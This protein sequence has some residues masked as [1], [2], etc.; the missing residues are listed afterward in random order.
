MKKNADNAIKRIVQKLL[1]SNKAFIVAIILFVVMSMLSPNFLSRAN[2]LNLLKQI[3]TNTIAALGFTFLIGSGHIDLSVGSVVGFLGVIMGM[4]IVRAGMPIW[5]AILVG[6]ICGAAIGSLSAIIIS[7]FSLPPFVVTLAMQS[8]FRG[9]IYIITKLSPITGFPKEFIF[10]GQGNVLGF[11]MPVII[12]IAM[13]IIMYIVSKR[14]MFGRYV[15]AMGGNTEATRASG[16]SITKTRIAIYAVMGVCSAIASVILTARV[17][18]ATIGAGEG[19]ELDA[20]SSVVIGGTS[21]T[22]GSV[23]I[24]GTVFGALIIGLCANGMN[25][26]GIQ[27]NYQIISKGILIL[28][29]LVLDVVTTRFYE[30]VRRKQALA[31]LEKDMGKN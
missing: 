19:M 26:L 2:L 27:T 17:A 5:F 11:P 21:M 9:L 3:C 20:I 4:L 22:G 15:I 24:I 31:V 7:I 23:N 29:A 12:M 1:L 16:I 8:L 28:M 18:S 30:K 10:L 25:L 6:I 14:T 13:I